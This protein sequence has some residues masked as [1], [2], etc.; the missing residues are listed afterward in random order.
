MAVNENTGRGISLFILAWVI[1]PVNDVCAKILG[2]LDYPLL[3]VVWARFFFSFLVL[4]PAAIISGQKAFV[5]PSNLYIQTLRAFLLVCATLGFFKGLQTLPL[6]ETLAIY[7]VYLFF[8]TVFS[9]IF[10]REIPGTRRWVA[11]IIGFCGS[12]LVIRPG[13]DVLPPGAIYVVAAAFA[14]AGYHLLTRR[15]SADGG[16]WQ[17]LVFQTVLGTLMTSPAIFFVWKVP[18]FMAIWLFFGMGLTVSI[19]HYLVIRAYQYA[20]ASILAPFSYVEIISATLLGL[21]VFGDFPDIMTWL[22]V[23]VMVFSGLYI[24]F[25]EGKAKSFYAT[26]VQ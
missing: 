4:L 20:Q 1:V 6:A 22:G 19:G 24:G 26:K 11:V 9:P 23:I 12:L 25:R 18:D 17:V 3:M 10:L 21:V 15:I 14:F 2:N 8:V 5:F 16:H 7:F 13:L